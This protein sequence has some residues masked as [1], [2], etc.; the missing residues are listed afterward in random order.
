MTGGGCMCGVCHSEDPILAG[1]G[2]SRL[3]ARRG[4]VWHGRGNAIA[5]PTISMMP[6]ADEHNDSVA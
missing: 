3:G 4:D 2:R 1:P 6:R 5:L